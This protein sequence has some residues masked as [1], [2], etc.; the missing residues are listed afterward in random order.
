MKTEIREIY[1][2]E[3]CN[4]LY[5]RKHICEYHERICIKNNENKRACYGCK[6]LDKKN[7]DYYAGYGDV[8]GEEVVENANLLFCSKLQTCI[9]TPQSEVRKNA[10]ETIGYENNPMPKECEYFV[11]VTY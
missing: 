11:P 5:Q 1:K 4:K 2:C 9:H 8:N 7:V 3:H 6:N 10:L